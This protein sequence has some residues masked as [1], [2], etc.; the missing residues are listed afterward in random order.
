MQMFGALDK[1]T[2]FP[3][4][5]LFYGPYVNCFL[6]FCAITFHVEHRLCMTFGNIYFCYLIVQN[7][8]SSKHVEAVKVS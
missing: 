6:F 2:F 3:C 1:F 4:G 8:I 5:F 7:F